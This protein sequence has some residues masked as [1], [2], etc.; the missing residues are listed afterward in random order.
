[1]GVGIVDGGR[2][3]FGGLVVGSRWKVGRGRRGDAMGWVWVWEAIGDWGDG[4]IGRWT[5]WCGK[6]GSK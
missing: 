2:V 5:V 3:F 1:M 6:M 4:R